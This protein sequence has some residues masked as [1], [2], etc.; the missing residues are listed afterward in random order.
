M[1]RMMTALFVLLLALCT[2]GA[3]DF[4]DD[5]GY[6]GETDMWPISQNGRWGFIDHR[7]EAVLPCEWEACCP[8]GI[9]AE[10]K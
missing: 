3:E 8:S 9:P 4:F 10:Q 7:G 1:K 6:Y 2:A 5:L